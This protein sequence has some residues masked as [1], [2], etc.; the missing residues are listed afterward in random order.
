MVR[1][2]PQ[3]SSI[4]RSGRGFRPRVASYPAAH[5]RR[6]D[7]FMGELP[8]TVSEFLVGQ[9]PGREDLS[10]TDV[11]ERKL[12]MVGYD[13]VREYAGIELTQDLFDRNPP[14][15]NHR[16]TPHDLAIDLDPI[17]SPFLASMLRHR[18]ATGSP[19]S[20]CMRR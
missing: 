18:R 2:L 19:P 6:V 13:V 8:R 17:A 15:A 5:E 3:Y 9:V 20:F 14:P 12:R 1:R 11:I 10:R 4:R 7:A 16:L